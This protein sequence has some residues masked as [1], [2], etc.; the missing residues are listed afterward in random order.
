MSRDPL[1]E[2]AKAVD[3]ALADRD[4]RINQLEQLLRRLANNVAAPS[5]SEGLDRWMQHNMHYGNAMLLIGYGGFFALWSST[6]GD[7]PKGWFG[8]SGLLM[9]LS[10]LLFVTWELAKTAASSYKST[11]GAD[12]TETNKVLSTMDR[13]W[14]WVFVPTALLGMFAGFIVLCFFARHA[15]ISNY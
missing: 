5:H 10:L 15:L 9:G 1:Q 3:R 2:M 14:A 6:A 4:K 11:K 13:L 8:L 12:V 7:M